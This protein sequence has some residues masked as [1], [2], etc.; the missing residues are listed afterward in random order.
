MDIDKISP[1]Q[2]QKNL[3]EL[4][5]RYESLLSRVEVLQELVDTLENRLQG[6]VKDESNLE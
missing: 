6:D 3:D 4:Q 2:L 5:E 1:Y